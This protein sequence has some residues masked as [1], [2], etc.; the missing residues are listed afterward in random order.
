M[1]QQE[2]QNIEHLLGI[3][4][5][6]LRLLPG[7]SATRIRALAK[8]MEKDYEKIEKLIKLRREYV[9]RVSPVEQVIDKERKRLTQEEQEIMVGEW[10]SRRFDAGLFS[11]Q[12]IDVILAWLVAEDDGAKKKI[13]SLLADRDGDLSLVRKTLQEQMEGLTE[14][15]PGQKDLKDMLETL[16]QFL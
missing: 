13:Q 1:H 7:G 12:L 16:L 2:L 3:F 8:F 4:A 14:E 5:S 10:L 11:L 6:L 9:S 15:E